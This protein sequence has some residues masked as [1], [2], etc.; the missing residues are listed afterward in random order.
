MDLLTVFLGVSTLL[1]VRSAY[2]VQVKNRDLCRENAKLNALTTPISRKTF[3]E[4]QS[5][6]GSDSWSDT[7]KR[8]ALGKAGIRFVEIQNGTSSVDVQ[9]IVLQLL[10]RRWVVERSFALGNPMQTADQG[11]RALRQ[12]PCRLPRRR[13]R[14]QSC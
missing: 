11:L 12:H 9:R 8:I 13:I 3:E 4:R 5:E 7:I 6:H 1:A 2:R 10:P 14:L